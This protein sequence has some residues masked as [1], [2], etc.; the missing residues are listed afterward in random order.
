M[1]TYIVETHL[2]AFE[3]QAAS[4][5]KALSNI[6]FRLFGRRG[7]VNTSYWT[8]KE[9]TNVSR[10]SNPRAVGSYCFG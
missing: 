7:F 4:A 8:V 1:K 9:K 2:G 10:S 5:E 6:R 3:T